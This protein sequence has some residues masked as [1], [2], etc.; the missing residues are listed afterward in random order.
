MDTYTSGNNGEIIISISKVKIGLAFLASV[1]LIGLGILLMTDRSFSNGTNYHNW[2]PWMIF[3]IGTI[4]V[5]FFGFTAYVTGRQFFM[6][7]PGLVANSSGIMFNPSL[8]SNSFVNWV[9]IDRFEIVKT[10]STKAIL[11]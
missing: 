6:V 11:I 4:A 8:S 9:D 3:G 5:L 2:P 7:G 1:A 10:K